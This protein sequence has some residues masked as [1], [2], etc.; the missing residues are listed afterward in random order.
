MLSK[1]VCKR[2]SMNFWPKLMGVLVDGWS[3]YDDIHWKNGFVLCPKQQ[4]Q[5][6]MLG[7]KQFIKKGPPEWCPYTLEHLLESQND[8]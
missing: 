6:E 2:C 1:T 8:K 7:R 5:G 4:W 3:K